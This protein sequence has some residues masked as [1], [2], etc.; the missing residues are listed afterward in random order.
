VKSAQRFDTKD[1]VDLGSFAGLLVRHAPGTAIA[2][3]AQRVVDQVR[4]SA[5]VFAQ[6]KKGKDVKDAEGLSI[7]LPQLEPDTELD[8]KRLD[9]ASDTRWPQFIHARVSR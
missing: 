6:R 7:Y 3:A 8:Y 4:S 5:L 2:T 1:F 9:F